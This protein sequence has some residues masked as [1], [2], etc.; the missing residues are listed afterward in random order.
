M[1]SWRRRYTSLS[2]HWPRKAQHLAWLIRGASTSYI[3]HLIESPFI[4]SYSYILS[5]YT[6]L[7]SWKNVVKLEFSLAHP[8]ILYLDS[9]A[10]FCIC[11]PWIG[12][13]NNFVRCMKK[14]AITFCQYGRALFV[15]LIP[16]KVLTET[17]LPQKAAS[18]K[19]PNKNSWG[20][21]FVIPQKSSNVQSC[22]LF[23]NKTLNLNHLMILTDLSI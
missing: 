5:L 3:E 4:G 16:N 15:V 12:S 17:L 23:W 13:V 10:D 11:S 22:I 7:G 21:G 14:Q 20:P 6:I 9:A 8:C 1:F 2:H 19:S 18:H